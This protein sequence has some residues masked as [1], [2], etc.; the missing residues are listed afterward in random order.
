MKQLKITIEKKQPQD[1]NFILPNLCVHCASP[2][3][4]YE[5]ELYNQR[6]RLSQLF[7]AQIFGI[8]YALFS[9]IKTDEAICTTGLCGDCYRI[10]QTL[11]K[12][13]KWFLLQWFILSGLLAGIGA[14]PIVYFV[15]DSSYIMLPLFIAPL[16]AFFIIKY[17]ESKKIDRLKKEINPYFSKKILVNNL[18]ITPMGVFVRKKNMRYKLTAKVSNP[19]Y[20]RQF[21]KLNSYNSIIGYND[22]IWQRIKTKNDSGRKSVL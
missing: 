5:Y 4:N 12:I 10:L 2:D 17:F 7:L 13:N 8:F 1:K 9:A 22:Y 14:A 16:N 21:I 20:I 15:L 6:S 11:E 19:D 18:N 3:T